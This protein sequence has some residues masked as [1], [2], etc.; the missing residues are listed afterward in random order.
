M[1][2]R[3]SYLGLSREVWY[4]SF[5]TLINRAG[6]MVIPFLSLYLT[7]DKGFSLAQVGWLMSFFGLGSVLGSWLGGKL[8]DK[9][10][11]Y[12]VMTGSLLLSSLLFISLQF[13]DS[14]VALCAGI[15]VLMSV[16][17]A[18]RPA[19]FVALNAYSK[20]ENKTR[21]V[22]LVRLAINLGFAAGPAAG[23]FIIITLGYGGLFWIDGLTSLIAGLAL[24]KLLHPKK[25]RTIDE[26]V[27]DKEVSAYTDGKYWL[28][29]VSTILF[30]F[31]FMQ[32]FSTVPLYY[33]DVHFL[34]EANIGLLIG[35]NGLIVFLFE[36]PM[37]HALEKR[38]LS[39]VWLMIAG[40]L[41][42]GMSFL[43]FNLSAWTGILIIALLLMSFG[44]MLVFPFSNSFAMEYSKRGKRGEYMA[45]YS[46][47]FS[48]SHVF[49][50]N[51]G[52]QSIHHF[53][54]GITWY[55][56]VTIT[57]IG[58]VLLFLIRKVGKEKD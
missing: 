29:I 26:S 28:F 33:K 36:M 12:K 51:V 11:Y 16:A 27:S 5:I 44:E 39:K 48:I 30:G 52:M 49:S 42:L 20:P 24:L 45:L 13:L 4:L 38:K 41:L 32:Y 46:I 22:T 19:M 40:M 2:F 43:L 6:T 25:A 3:S 34:N 21:S 35:M 47:A 58:M 50:H 9:F 57:I 10:G 1:L 53:G 37:V 17:D 14:F 8:T 15:F 18:F 7:K 55:S 23:G 54:F 56:M 31:V